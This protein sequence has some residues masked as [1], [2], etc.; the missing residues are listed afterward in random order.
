MQVIYKKPGCS[1]ETIQVPN[2]LASL[3]HLVEGPIESV[4]L[5]PDYCFLC[6]E[7]GLLRGME[8]NVTIRG[9]PFFGPVLVVGINGE[10]FCDVPERVLKERVHG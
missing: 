8:Y 2:T 5:D 10:D 3:Q 9:I 6:N 7:K 4:T 1:P